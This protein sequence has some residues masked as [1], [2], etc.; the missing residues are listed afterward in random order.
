MATPTPT[1]EHSNVDPM[2]SFRELTSSSSDR[3][4]SKNINNKQAN[5]HELIYKNP[6]APH[7]MDQDENTPPVW[8]LVFMRI[9]P[10]PFSFIIYPWLLKIV[11]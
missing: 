9:D 6:S 3:S 7:D 4:K 11:I 1:L 5:G 2:M 10:R 8:A